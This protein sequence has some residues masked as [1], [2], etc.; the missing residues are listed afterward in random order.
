MA[1][2][3]P[4]FPRQYQGRKDHLDNAVVLIRSFGAPAR[5]FKPSRLV[6]LENDR[7]DDHP[8]GFASHKASC[9]HSSALLPII[10]PSSRSGLVNLA[11]PLRLLASRSGASRMHVS[12]S[13][14]RRDGKIDSLGS[15]A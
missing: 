6:A 11:L 8:L 9:H 15:E 12:F 7:F 1:I 5:R 10:S 13:Q 2:Y 14:T 4:Q 3:N